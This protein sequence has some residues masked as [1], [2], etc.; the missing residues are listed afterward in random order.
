M[1]ERRFWR[2]AP[3]IILALAGLYQIALLAIAISGR[4]GYPYDLEWMEGGL[5]H[6]ALRIRQG[7]GIYVAP[8]AD[9]IPYPYAPLYPTLLALFGGPFGI[10]YLLGRVVSILGLFGIA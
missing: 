5:L 3:W 9:F 1:G 8:N 7:Q 2:I 6:H 4:V 10:S